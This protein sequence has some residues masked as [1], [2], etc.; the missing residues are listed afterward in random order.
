MNIVKAPALPVMCMDVFS[1]CVKLPN[2]RG[3]RGQAPGLGYAAACRQEN[4]PVTI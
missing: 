3:R 2:P 4:P 1:R